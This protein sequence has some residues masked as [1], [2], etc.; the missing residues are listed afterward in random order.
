MAYIPAGD[1]RAYGKPYVD[2]TD[3]LWLS[4]Y[5]VDTLKRH[6]LLSLLKNRKISTLRRHIDIGER[7]D[8]ESGDTLTAFGKW[9]RKHIDG[10]LTMGK[11]KQMI[12]QGRPN[13]G[14]DELAT[15]NDWTPAGM[16]GR[17]TGARPSYDYPKSAPGKTDR[18]LPKRDQ[19]TGK[20]TAVGLSSFKK[21]KG[22]KVVND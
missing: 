1:L 13:D 16:I 20:F 19:N 18:Q 14:S 5:H 9:L 2:D 6:G 17:L 8:A 21:R 12:D 10:V 11:S 22:G 3:T 4:R 7:Y 15:A